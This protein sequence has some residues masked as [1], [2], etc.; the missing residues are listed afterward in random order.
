MIPL[1]STLTV[2]FQDGQRLR[3]MLDP[4]I[5]YWETTRCLAIAPKQPN[6]RNG[7]KQFT[8]ASLDPALAPVTA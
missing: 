3:I 5:D 4:G 2:H 8:I 7:E 6:V 1:Q